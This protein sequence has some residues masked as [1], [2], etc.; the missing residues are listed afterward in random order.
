MEGGMTNVEESNNEYGSEILRLLNKAVV[1]VNIFRDKLLS[2]G[3]VYRF[4]DW[5]DDYGVDNED[6]DKFR[7]EVNN[8]LSLVSNSYSGYSRFIQRLEEQYRHQLENDYTQLKLKYEPLVGKAVWEPHELNTRV[9]YFAFNTFVNI[10]L[11]E[12]KP[13]FLNKLADK[14]RSIIG[15]GDNDEFQSKYDV[16]ELMNKAGFTWRL[17]GGGYRRKKKRK[18]K[19]KSTKRKSSKRRT[20]KKRSKK[21]KYKKTKRRRH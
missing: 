11:S 3:R 19:R 14:V 8:M 15:T 9:I 1:A 5:E 6:Y 16:G 10:Y 2:K 21:R 12:R 20:T 13:D 18:N 4:E 17:P 7:R